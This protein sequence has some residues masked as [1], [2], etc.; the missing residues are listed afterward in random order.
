MNRD[1]AAIATRVRIEV[2]RVAA[3][4]L[5][6]GSGFLLGMAHERGLPAGAHDVTPSTVATVPVDRV[7]RTTACRCA[8]RGADE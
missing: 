1:H 4:F 8:D 2:A 5:A 6:A 7:E 3:F